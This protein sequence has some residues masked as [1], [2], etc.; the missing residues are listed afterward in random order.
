V[1]IA[2]QK[3]RVPEDIAVTGFDNIKESELT[4]PWLTTV[5]VHKQLIGELAAERVIKRRHIW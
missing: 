1:I 3:D 5:H 2:V 4:V